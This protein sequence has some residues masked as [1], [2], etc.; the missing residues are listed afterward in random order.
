MA[1]FKYKTKILTSLGNPIQKFNDNFIFW[2]DFQEIGVDFTTALSNGTSGYT[3]DPSN[4]SRLTNN[5]LDQV[6]VDRFKEQN[7]GLMVRFNNED[8]YIKEYNVGEIILNQPLSNSVTN[9]T[10]QFR[11]VGSIKNK[12]SGGFQTSGFSSTTLRVINNE[13]Y[14]R[15]G[16]TIRNTANTLPRF[17]YPIPSQFNTVTKYHHITDV[18]CNWRFPSGGDSGNGGTFINT[19]P[20]T[21]I[22]DGT[23]VIFLSRIA[24][25]SQTPN[26]FNNLLSP[27]IIQQT[28]ASQRFVPKVVDRDSTGSRFHIENTLYTVNGTNQGTIINR[29]TH[30]FFTFGFHNFGGNVDGRF[31]EL[32]YVF[33]LGNANTLNT[34]ELNRFM[35]YLNIKY[36]K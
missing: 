6:H 29:T 34:K 22:A 25:D 32:S 2:N 12:A 30:P 20:T 21:N 11:Y 3:S 36:N 9:A 35:K 17:L 15:K 4:L 10:L 24:W 26:H 31:Q 14:G 16:F 19:N 8:R 18:S 23:N 7:T 1:V 5:L 33:V 13:V 27:L 28:N